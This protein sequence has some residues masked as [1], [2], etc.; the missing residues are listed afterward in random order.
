M[1]RTKFPGSLVM[2]YESE[3]NKE[4]RNLFPDGIE[5]KDFLDLAYYVSLRTNRPLSRDDKR[6]N[7]YLNVW[8][9]MNDDVSIDDSKKVQR[10][11]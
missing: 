9:Y 7:Y 1:S 10:P 8:F 2:K 6:S 11:D 4:L 5:F 3:C